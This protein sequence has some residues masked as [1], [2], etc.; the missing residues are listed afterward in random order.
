MRKLLKYELLAYRA[1]HL[2]TM[3]V[4]LLA[5]PLLGWL[6][7]YLGLRHT[8]PVH[9]GLFTLNAVMG[10][11][12]RPFLQYSSFSRKISPLPLP[13]LLPTPH[14][15][16]LLA[17]LLG[18]LPLWTAAVIGHAVLMFSFRHKLDI[19]PLDAWQSLLL[20]VTY[21][22]VQSIFAFLAVVGQALQGGFSL[23]QKWRFLT[24]LTSLFGKVASAA[25]LPFAFIPLIIVQAQLMIF[26]ELTAMVQGGN[27]LGM[28]VAI[29]LLM[30]ASA[31][32]LEKYCNY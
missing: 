12:I 5:A 27:V 32:V 21:L 30:C 18:S 16:A 7:Y 23:P 4:V 10:T 26:P 2:N 11:A 31:H 17:K 24:P 15:L 13:L 19:Q 22:L 20:T 6:S 8:I 3:L 14:L 9:I 28:G 25:A 1:W 29:G